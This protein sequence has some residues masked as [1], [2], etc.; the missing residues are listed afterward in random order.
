MKE[1]IQNTEPYRGL[2]QLISHYAAKHDTLPQCAELAVCTVIRCEN[3]RQLTTEIMRYIQERKIGGS[4]RVVIAG[5]IADAGGIA[6]YDIMLTSIAEAGERVLLQRLLAHAKRKMSAQQ[7][8]AIAKYVGSKSRDLFGNITE[9]FILDKLAAAILD[10]GTANP[11]YAQHLA[12]V[13]YGMA[14]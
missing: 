7:L 12:P 11:T 3:D 6:V 13:R 4:Q 1:N 14:S 2:V 8:L 9:L 10:G 5:R